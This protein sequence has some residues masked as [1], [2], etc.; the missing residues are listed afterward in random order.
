LAGLTL[1]DMPTV[2]QAKEMQRDKKEMKA[3]E[4]AQKWALINSTSLSKS[5]GEIRLACAL[6]QS[7]ASFAEALKERALTLALVTAEDIRR[8]EISN[9]AKKIIMPDVSLPALKE[10]DLVVI[11][12]HGHQIRL[13]Q[14]TTGL[15]REKLENY[16]STVDRSELMSVSDV[17]AVGREVKE[18][19][20]REYEHARKERAQRIGSRLYNHADMASQQ[21][22]A[23]RE[24]KRRN[25]PKSMPL[26]PDAH[27]EQLEQA[28]TA[29]HEERYRAGKE[30]TARER[31][32]ENETPRNQREAKATDKKARTEQSD[33]LLAQQQK[34]AMLELFEFRNPGVGQTAKER[35]ERERE[36]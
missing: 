17:K 8:A 28:A 10:N 3:Q 25:A 31:Q 6:T 1:Q 33:T 29:R 30:T 19:R 32:K 5:A 4:Q 2:A 23:M 22:D 20:R 34:Q 35:F 14:R 12:R 15:S 36:R 24:V 11:N 9:A 16:F 27:R 21:R 7:G 26:H 18:E 13:T